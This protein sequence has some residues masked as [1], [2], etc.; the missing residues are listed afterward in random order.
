MFMRS[1][2]PYKMPGCHYRVSNLRRLVPPVLVHVADPVACCLSKGIIQ[3]PSTR[4]TPSPKLCVTRTN[5]SKPSP[6]SATRMTRCSSSLPAV[7]D[8]SRATWSQMGP[9]RTVTLSSALPTMA[10]AGFLTHLLYCLSSEGYSGVLLRFT[11]VRGH[12]R[13]ALIVCAEI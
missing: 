9:A 12:L 4:S 5:G 6:T 2:A 8:S 3:S 7:Q 13:D 11:M 10:T 1:A